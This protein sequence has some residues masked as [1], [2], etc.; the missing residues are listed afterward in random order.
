MNILANMK[1]LDQAKK[2]IYITCICL[3]ILVLITS[4]ANVLLL[5]EYHFPLIAIK[6]SCL[7]EVLFSLKWLAILIIAIAYFKLFWVDKKSS[8]FY[9]IMLIVSLILVVF[10]LPH[11][12][13]FFKFPKEIWIIINLIDLIWALTVIAAVRSK[14]RFNNLS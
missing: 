3:I 12:F 9:Y 6:G 11:P 2:L 7:F 4:I 5:C 8:I 14:R 13:D 10:H 1:L